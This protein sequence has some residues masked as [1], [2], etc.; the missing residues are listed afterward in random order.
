VLIIEL[1]S[2]LCK[3]CNY[4]F[5]HPCHRITALPKPCHPIFREFGWQ[6]L[7]P[8]CH[9]ESRSKNKT[10]MSNISGTPVFAGLV[11]SSRTFKTSAF[12]HSAIS[13]EEKPASAIIAGISGEVN[14]QNGVLVG[15]MGC[16][17]AVLVG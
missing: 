9:P 8:F 14:A 15:L 17:E 2:D 5:I 6:L 13:P 16:F 1:P 4:S 7:L 10:P 3:A 11:G 12:N